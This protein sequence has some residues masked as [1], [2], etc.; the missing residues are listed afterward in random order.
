MEVG[1]GEPDEREQSAHAAHHH[2]AVPEPALGVEAPR[3]LRGGLLPEAA[4]PP[5]RRRTRHRVARLDPAVAGLGAIR[6]DAQQCHEV[7]PLPGARER[8][9]DVLAEALVVG[10]EVV[11]RVKRHRVARGPTAGQHQQRVQD[12]GRGAAVL[13]LRHHRGDPHVGEE[14]DVEALVGPVDHHQRPM[15]GHRLRD[16]AASLGQERV[17]RD[18]G[19][20]LLG[21]LVAGDAAGHGAQAHPV[22]AGQDHRPAPAHRAAPSPICRRNLPTSAVQPV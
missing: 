15:R 22:P 8:G 16:P 17:L 4:H 2:E 21:P 11:R 12:R 6:G 20:E 3:V 14:R 13:R 19:A 9:L 1:R 18:E 5:Q 10:Y 7:R